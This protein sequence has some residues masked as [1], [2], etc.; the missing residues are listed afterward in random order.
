[1]FIPPLGYVL[2]PLGIIA[3]AKGTCLLFWLTL[4]TSCLFAASVFHPAIW[5]DRIQPA[6]YFGALL[7]VRTVLDY[8]VAA[9][10]FKKVVQK[11]YVL[12]GFL[13]LA[14]LCSLLMPLLLTGWVQVLPIDESHFTEVGKRPWQELTHPLSIGR[15][16]FTQLL[17]PFAGIIICIAAVKKF[18]TVKDLKFA[19]RLFFAQGVFVLL[20]GALYQ[21]SFITGK[22]SLWE[23]FCWLTG[24]GVDAAQFHSI[25]MFS[26]AGEPG[27]TSCFL[28]MCTGLMTPI[29]V[30]G[31]ETSLASKRLSH[32]L[33]WVFWFGL[34][35][36]LSTTGFFGAILLVLLSTA[37]VFYEYKTSGFASPARLVKVLAVVSVVFVFVALLVGYCRSTDTTY[38]YTTGFEYLKNLIFEKPLQ[39]LDS[40]SLFPRALLARR[41]V[42][43]FVRSPVL[44]IG[45]GSHR[46]ASLLTVFL[47]NT[48]LIGT[49]A[50]IS[51][52]LFA[53]RKSLFVYRHTTCHQTSAI[54]LSAS[55]AFLILLIVL[56]LGQSTVALNFVYYWGLLALCYGVYNVSARCQPQ[57]S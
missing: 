49:L 27:Y 17:Y 13:G 55:T 52:N 10:P 1:M 44:G 24:Q 22:H 43:L 29:C 6:H 41:A 20:T 38:I 9:K 2:L 14:L 11:E 39:F 26:I 56:L 8:L 35:L 5:T 30:L 54:A 12:F 33:L 34:F 28:L 42:E 31:R 21:L 37:L 32:L 46:S 51:V 50:F 23:G 16:N 7:V 19:I 48:G 3:F 25:R 15:T 40:K 57:N 4:G 47:A 18:K 45:W 53:V 36:S